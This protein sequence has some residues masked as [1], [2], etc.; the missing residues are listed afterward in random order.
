MTLSTAR[1]LG[2]AFVLSVFLLGCSQQ[3]PD[4]RAADEAVIRAA[5]ATWSTAAGAKQLDATVAYYSAD[6]SLLAPNA[7][8]AT[9]AEAIRATWTQLLALH[10]FSIHWQ[11]AKVE[12]ARS[13]DLAFAQ[14]TYELT[15]TNAQGSPVTDRGKYVDVWKKQADG[16]WKVV[17]DIFNSDLPLPPP[18]SSK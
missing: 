6:A 2:T 4:T 1:S 18:P 5:E 15:T 7:P 14:G 8:I 10:G 16:T 11:P 13:A 17:A 3:L 9:G 12:V